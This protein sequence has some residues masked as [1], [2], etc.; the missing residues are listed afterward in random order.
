MSEL[1]WQ[2]SNLTII[3]LV[4][5]C[6]SFNPTPQ[7][8]VTLVNLGWCKGAAGGKGGARGNQEEVSSSSDP[9]LV[10]PGSTTV[11]NMGKLAS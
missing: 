10:D 3:L 7:V 5:L 6:L 11:K 4:L 8:T 9:S 1:C 2:P